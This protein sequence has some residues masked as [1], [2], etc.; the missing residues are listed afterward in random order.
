MPFSLDHENNAD[1]CSYY[2]SEWTNNNGDEK[3]EGFIIEADFI[4]EV[5]TKQLDECA[6][7][8]VVQDGADGNPHCG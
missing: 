7:N 5:L 1:Y 4:P 8:Q 2:K 6:V 3:E